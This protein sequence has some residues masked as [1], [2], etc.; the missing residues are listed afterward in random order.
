MLLAKYFCYLMWLVII[1]K[2]YAL[3]A[4]FFAKVNIYIEKR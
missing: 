3:H 4:F 1:I 2:Y